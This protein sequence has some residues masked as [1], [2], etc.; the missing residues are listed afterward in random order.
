M[1][2]GKKSLWR[3]WQETFY[4]AIAL[5]WF[6]GYTKLGDTEKEQVRENN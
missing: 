6:L 5:V 4:S 3:H 2:S 1:G